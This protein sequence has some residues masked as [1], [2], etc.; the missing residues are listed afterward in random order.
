MAVD[1]FAGIPVTDYSTALSWYETLLGAPPAFIPNDTE[2]VWE[3]AEHRYVYIELLPEHAGH[4]RHTVFVGDLDARVAAT[5]ERGLEPA[6]RETYD[7][8]VRKITYVDPDGNEI[9]FGGEPL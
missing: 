4:A 6:R 2:A 7:N 5:A 3:L 9:G 1:L 8:G